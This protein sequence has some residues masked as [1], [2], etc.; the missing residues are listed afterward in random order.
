MAKVGCTSSLAD[1]RP[2][3]NDDL[4]V[5]ELL[6]LLGVAGIQFASRT[7]ASRS[8]CLNCLAY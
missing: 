5:E 7:S 8:G 6:L 3:L 4:L 2:P 1:G